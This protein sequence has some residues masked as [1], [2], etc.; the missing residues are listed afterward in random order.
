MLL[1]AQQDY[2]ALPMYH[3]VPSILAKLPTKLNNVSLELE[4]TW[5]RVFWPWLFIE[6][7]AGGLLVLPEI[8][9]YREVEQPP[10]IHGSSR[11]PR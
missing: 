9:G 7:C 1:E 2:Q 8:R 10:I 3:S 4:R 5:S 6:A 11:L